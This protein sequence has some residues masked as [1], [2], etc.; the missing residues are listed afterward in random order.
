MSPRPAQPEQQSVHS[1]FKVVK[2]KRD[3]TPGASKQRSEAQQQ[4]SLSACTL[5]TG[6]TGLGNGGL[7][8]CTLGTPPASPGKQ[9]HDKNTGAGGENERHRRLRLLHEQDDDYRDDADSHITWSRGSTV[10]LHHSITTL[11]RPSSHLSGLRD[12]QP[13]T[14]QQLPL[15]A[16]LPFPSSAANAPSAAA[17]CFPSTAAANAPTATALC[18][19]STAAAANAPTPTADTAAATAVPA[20]SQQ[21]Q[22]Q[23]HQHLLFPSKRSIGFGCGDNKASSGAARSGRG[24]SSGMRD[25]GRGRSSGRRD[26]R[27]VACDVVCC[28]CSKV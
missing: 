23:Q 10:D 3:D 19:P 5:S 28:C 16:A 14:Q 17:L 9:Q 11:G 1:H 6:L 18:F 13:A 22:D 4:H 24:R 12:S 27:C 26:S 21:H 25:S 15:T 2:Q 20:S 8:S 7:L